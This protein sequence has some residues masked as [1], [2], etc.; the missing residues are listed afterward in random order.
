MTLG[1]AGLRGAI[2]SPETNGVIP[3]TP[4]AKTADGVYIAYQV[5]GEHEL[6]GVPDRWR[7]CRVV[8]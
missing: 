1:R 4:Y 7:L 8:G 5:A 2:A 6:K 3:E